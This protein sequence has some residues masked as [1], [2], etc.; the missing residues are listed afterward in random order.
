MRVIVLSEEIYYI[1]KYKSSTEQYIPP[2]DVELEIESLNEEHFNTSV[3]D[4]DVS[5]VHISVPRYN[6]EG[7]FY[8]I[9]KLRKDVERA[10]DHGRTVI[11]IPETI[12][13]RPRVRQPGMSDQIGESI[14]GNA[15]RQ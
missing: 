11:C 10:L 7:Y 2:T 9:P 13:F 14:Y 8:S 5:I 12:N 6:P 4:Y 3:F 15:R 1:E